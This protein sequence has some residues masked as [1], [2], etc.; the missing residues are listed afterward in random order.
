M[1]NDWLAAV[2]PDD[3]FN[4]AASPW[5]AI[6]PGEDEVY[7]LEQHGLGLLVKA[8]IM[9]GMPVFTG[10]V[11]AVSKLVTVSAVHVRGECALVWK[12]RADGLPATPCD[13][14]L[15]ALIALI[16]ENT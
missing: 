11:T 12:A 16:L 5:P 9:T 7:G 10:W 8:D 6:R 1:N 13:A 3:Y 15:A 14:P 2:A 4:G